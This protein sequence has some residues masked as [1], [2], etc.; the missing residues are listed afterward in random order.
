MGGGPQVIDD[1][2]EDG[3]V[4]ES[5][6]VLSSVGIAA[7]ISAY[8]RISINRFKNDKN[9]ICIYSDTDSVVLQKNLEDRFVND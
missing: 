4:K 2:K 6:G 7:A 8:A 5:K 1:K 3:L 9:N